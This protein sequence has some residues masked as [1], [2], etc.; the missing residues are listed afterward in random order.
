MMC[1]ALMPR[2]RPAT[3][4][5]LKAQKAALAKRELSKCQTFNIKQIITRNGTVL[6]N[7]LERMLETTSINARDI[8]TGYTLLE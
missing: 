7:V 1:L 6:M 2:I 4:A 5:A 3:G 8:E